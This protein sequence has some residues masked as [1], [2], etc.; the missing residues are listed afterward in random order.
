MKQPK[1]ATYFVH[2]EPGYRERNSRHR[3]GTEFELKEGKSADQLRGASDDS[4]YNSYT[5]G[6]KGA[7]VPV[8][9]RRLYSAEKRGDLAVS[10]E[11]ITS[12]H[13]ASCPGRPCGERG[14]PRS[15]V[16]GDP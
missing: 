4:E 15:K 7:R 11:K 10:N 16:D 12:D 6:R 5:K 3:R 2:N 1:A 14:S 8:K 13:G 9:L